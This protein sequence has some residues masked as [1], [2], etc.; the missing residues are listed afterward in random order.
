MI[1]QD[2]LALLHHLR[3]AWAGGNAR[4]RSGASLA[5]VPG[6]AEGRVAHWAFG[7]AAGILE[8]AARRRLVIGAGLAPSADETA[9][10]RVARALGQGDWRAAGDAALW[11]VRRD[12]VDAF[13]SALAP[14]ACALYGP[15][16]RT[17]QGKAAP[18]R[19]NAATA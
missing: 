16:R 3:A 15:G 10:L 1:T 6:R 5:A 4:A 19:L 13:L 11:I 9:L 7:R 2:D 14:A 12:A 18:R 8:H 17:G